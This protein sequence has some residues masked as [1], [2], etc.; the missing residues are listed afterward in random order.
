MLDWHSFA[1]EAS[2]DY[3]LIGV[4]EDGE[5]DLPEVDGIPQIPSYYEL[6][7]QLTAAANAQRC[8]AAHRAR[9][10]AAQAANE[11]EQAARALEQAVNNARI[12][13]ELATTAMRS[14]EMRATLAVPWRPPNR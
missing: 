11:A 13:A 4:R 12:A 5:A 8:E 2:V 10:R 7:P 6:I 1:I 3:G 9:L 14:I